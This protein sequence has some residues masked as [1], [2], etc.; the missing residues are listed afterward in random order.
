MAVS[1]F[2]P[3]DDMIFEEQ[4][5][6][7]TG[8]LTTEKMSV[9]PEWLL[10]HFKFA[11]D[12]IEMMDKTKVYRYKDLQLPCS[13]RVKKAFDD[14]EQTFRSAYENGYEGMAALEDRLLFCG[15]AASSMACCI[16]KCNMKRSGCGR[17]G[18]ASSSPIC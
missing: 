13:P 14:L 16:M 6:F 15:P 12:R 10:A 2:N 7:L 17:W 18:K 1:L 11:D 3:F 9:F 4:F 5:C 8:D